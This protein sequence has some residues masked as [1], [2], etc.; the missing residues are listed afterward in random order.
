MEHVGC[1]IESVH[2]FRVVELIFTVTWGIL[3]QEY[4]EIL[5]RRI[6]RLQN[7]RHRPDQFTVLVR[8]IPLCPEHGTRSCNVDHFFS[9]H[10]PDSCSSCQMLYYGKDIEDLLVRW[11]NIIDGWMLHLL[12]S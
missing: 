4:H 7:I 8:G 11:I 1:H 10:Y 5:F 12:F 6:Q 9:K 2:L 3:M